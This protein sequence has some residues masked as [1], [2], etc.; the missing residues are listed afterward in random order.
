MV[1]VPLPAV[2]EWYDEK[3]EMPELAQNGSGTLHLQDFIAEG[4]GH[5]LQHRGPDHETSLFLGE[6]GQDLL[7]EQVDD[8]AAAAP[9]RRDEGVRVSPL[10]GEGSEVDARRPPLGALDQDVDICAF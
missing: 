10:H 1:A 8:K 7:R 9:E 6:G 3:V 4:S 2:V 5:P